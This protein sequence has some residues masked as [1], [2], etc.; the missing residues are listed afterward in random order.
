MGKNYKL[1]TDALLYYDEFSTKIL[2]GTKCVEIFDDTQ[3]Y[4]SLLK[5]RE[6]SLSDL[7]ND[8]VEVLIEYNL[9]IKNYTHY[10]ENS[11]ILN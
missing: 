6:W 10:Y 4:F 7:P 11:E 3:T 5:K 9:I 8:L 1:K 2:L